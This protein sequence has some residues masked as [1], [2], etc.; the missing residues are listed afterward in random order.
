MAF[1]T[2]LLL[3]GVLFLYLI[4]AIVAVVFIGA[5]LIVTIVFAVGSKGRAA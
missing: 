4:L 5:S 3:N 2:V 1:G